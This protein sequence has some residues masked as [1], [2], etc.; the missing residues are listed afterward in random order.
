[1]KHIA[2]LTLTAL[3]LCGLL[4]GCTPSGSKKP[5]PALDPIPIIPNQTAPRP[6]NPIATIPRP[7]DDADYQLPP[8]ERPT[9]VPEIK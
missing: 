3:L 6:T 1:M 4:C 9:I 8:G 2:I 5:E 7:T